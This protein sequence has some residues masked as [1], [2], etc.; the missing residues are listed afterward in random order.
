MNYPWLDEYLLSM[1]QATKDYKEEW[2]WTRYM[3]EGKLYAA[4][5]KDATGMRDIITLKLDPMDGDF[6]RQQYEEIIPGHYMNKIHWNS[7]YLD[8]NI[9]EDLMKDLIEKSYYLVR[10]SLSKKMQSEIENS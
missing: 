6:L 4:I 3:I 2:Q 9:P 1:K 5:C 10:G 7:V 8:G